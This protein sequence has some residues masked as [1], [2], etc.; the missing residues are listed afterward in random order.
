MRLK[1]SPLAVKDAMGKAEKNT[2]LAVE[3]LEAAREE[4]KKA[5]QLPNLPGYMEWQLRL[6]DNG[7]ERQIG[8]VRYAIERV[9]AVLPK[10][11]ALKA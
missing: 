9:L 8:V 4:V 10:D 1:W 7:L 6:L 2:Q 5:L 11:E 3:P